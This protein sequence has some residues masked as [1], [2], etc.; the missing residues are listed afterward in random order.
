[1]ASKVFEDPLV[2]C[3]ESQVGSER[4]ANE[5]MPERGFEGGLRSGETASRRS[6]LPSGYGFHSEG[7][8]P[9]HI[10]TVILSSV[11]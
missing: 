10:E 4:E 7:Q 1:M 8:S 11:M 2:S 9:I 5:K 6:A 3:Y